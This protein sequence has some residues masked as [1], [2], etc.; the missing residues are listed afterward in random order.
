MALCLL[1]ATEVPN[2]QTDGLGTF[3]DL[4]LILGLIGLVLLLFFF[5][6]IV[7]VR[8]HFSRQKQSKRIDQNVPSTD[9]WREAGRRVLPNDYQHKQSNDRDP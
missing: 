9:P 2:H 1:S 3:L 5:G 8:A 6:L 7:L 4:A